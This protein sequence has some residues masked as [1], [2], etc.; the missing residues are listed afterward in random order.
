[1]EDEGSKVGV[2]VRRKSDFDDED[3]DSHRDDADV[4]PG[5]RVH[6]C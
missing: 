3:R 4:H 5:L 6:E 2:G 1:M